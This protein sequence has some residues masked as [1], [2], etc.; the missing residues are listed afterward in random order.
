M[1][2]LISPRPASS[3]AI[4]DT[5]VQNMGTYRGQLKAPD[6]LGMMMLANIRA[7]GLE[8]WRKYRARGERDAGRDR[9][10]LRRRSW[11]S[12]GRRNCRSVSTSSASRAGSRAARSTSCARGQSSS[13]CRPRPRSSS[14]ARSR[15]TISSPRGRSANRTAMS[16]SR[17]TTRSSTSRAI[18]RRKDAL[19]TSIISQVTPSESSV[20]KRLAYEPMYPRPSARRSSASAASRAWRCTSR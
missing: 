19:F 7:G 15:P 2:R 3:R 20:V 11:R 10:R 16:R 6:R 12:R 4:P 1:P 8:H 14:R 13:W 18:T 17:T 5:G 9:R